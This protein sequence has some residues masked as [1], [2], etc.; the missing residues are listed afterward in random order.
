MKLQISFKQKTR[1]VYLPYVLVLGK[2]LN[3]HQFLKDMAD[4]ANLD[5]VLSEEPLTRDFRTKYQ[6]KFTDKESN[7][8]P[9]R[10]YMNKWE[11]GI[12]IIRRNKNYYCSTLVGI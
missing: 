5:R 8:V 4:I 3:S 9:Y 12:I 7:K 10:M 11:L 2:G 6:R 1:K